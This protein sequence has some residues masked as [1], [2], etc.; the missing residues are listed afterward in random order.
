MKD[1]QLVRTYK[2]ITLTCNFNLEVH[3]VSSV[4][5]STVKKWTTTPNIYES[6][7]ICTYVCDSVGWYLWMKKAMARNGEPSTSLCWRTEF[8]SRSV[9]V[10]RVFFLS[11][12][13]SRTGH[14][15]CLNAAL[16]SVITYVCQYRLPLGRHLL[17]CYT[18]KHNIYVKGPGLG[19]FMCM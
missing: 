15:V 8:V 2:L 11:R 1:S 12:G 5:L 3:D 17:T 4:T 13:E 10:L 14:L 19:T 9:E 16:S 6:L 7:C 18:Y